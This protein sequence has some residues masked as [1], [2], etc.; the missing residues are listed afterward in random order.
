MTGRRRTIALALLALATPLPAFALENGALDP[1]TTAAGPAGIGVSTSLGSCGVLEGG[2]AC[3]LNV[4]FGAVEGADSYTAAVTRADG[5]VIDYGSVGAGGTS[6]W[7]PYVGAGTY[8]V[9]ITAYGTPE[10]PAEDAE[11]R[12]DVIATGYSAADENDPAD[13]DDKPGSADEATEDLDVQVGPSD[14][15]PIEGN[16][17]PDGETQTNPGASETAP[18]TTCPTPA[19]P[20][21]APP[22][23]PEE[24]P[25]DL[26][27]DNLDEDLDGIPDEQERI[28][29]EQQLAEY[30]AALAAQAQ[31]TA[32]PTC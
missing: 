10:T 11:G 8:S 4:S 1:V 28:T 27:P 2:V 6:L 20:A 15:S 13:G 16:T 7:V 21:P 17:D 12:G 24:P 32:A 19:A 30:E 18:D 22:I 23:P 31:A 29:Y 26:D 14:G 5:S 9:R 25:E 3:E